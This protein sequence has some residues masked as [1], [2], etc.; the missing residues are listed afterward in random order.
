MRSLD[1]KIMNL[2][3]AYDK[4]SE[5][6]N[7]YDGSNE[8]IRDSLIQSF[9][10]TFVLCHKTLYEFMKNE[11]ISSE[12]TFPRAIFKKAYANNLISDEGVWLQLLEDRNSTSHIYN[13]KLADEVALRIQKDYVTAIG[14]LIDRLENMM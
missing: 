11:G 10:F 6:S 1:F 4:L 2:K 5:V 12:T 13:E 7:Q 8:I 9:E 3:K 14:E